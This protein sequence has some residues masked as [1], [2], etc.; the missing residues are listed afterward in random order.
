MCERATDRSGLGT[1]C[2]EKQSKETGGRFD[3]K[4]G[5]SAFV[6]AGEGVGRARLSLLVLFSVSSQ[7]R[8]YS[9]RRQ[10][11]ATVRLPVAI[12]WS[13]S[14]KL[15]PDD[16]ACVGG[17]LRPR[18]FAAAEKAEEPVRHSTGRSVLTRLPSRDLLPSL[19]APN[20]GLPFLGRVGRDERARLGRRRTRPDTLLGSLPCR[21]RKRAIGQISRKWREGHARPGRAGRTEAVDCRTLGVGLSIGRLTLHAPLNVR[22]R[23]VSNLDSLADNGCLLP[24]ST[25]QS[26]WSF[27][28]SGMRMH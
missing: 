25:N 5:S 28:R 16:P 13:R 4:V 11:A 7:S 27:Q 26:E 22:D 2:E 10:R 19:L 24:I 3:R 8:G 18:P 1:G 23:D 14:F 9:R 15:L 20:N 12:V 21:Q 17:R 6:V